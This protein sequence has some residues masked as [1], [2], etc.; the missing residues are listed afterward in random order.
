[1]LLQ[2]PRA[3]T[4]MDGLTLMCWASVT[5]LCDPLRAG[6]GDCWP[7]ESLSSDPYRCCSSAFCWAARERATHTTHTSAHTQVERERHES[8]VEYCAEHCEG[9][10]TDRSVSSAVTYRLWE[11]STTRSHVFKRRYGGSRIGYKCKAEQKCARQKRNENQ[12]ECVFE[13]SREGRRGRHVCW[14]LPDCGW[15]K[16]TGVALLFLL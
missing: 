12:A 11:Y 3:M 1:M 13:M 4:L 8:S 5:T 6:E 7:G 9:K 16:T 15:W 10:S 2:W 14:R